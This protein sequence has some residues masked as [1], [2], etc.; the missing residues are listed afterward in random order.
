MRKFE[1][2]DVRLS[3]GGPGPERIYEIF[4]KAI[5]KKQWVERSLW[6]VARNDSEARD[7]AVKRF[8]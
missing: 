3:P 5:V 2:T 6:V 8:S 1:I 4:Y 7:Q